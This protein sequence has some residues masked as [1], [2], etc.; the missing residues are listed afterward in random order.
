MYCPVSIVLHY[1][2]FAIYEYRT[3]DDGDATQY[4]ITTLQGLAKR[5]RPDLVSFVT[6]VA[7]RAEKMRQYLVARMLQA[8]RGSNINAI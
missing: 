2:T 5:L 1:T 8:N 6:A 4:L 3:C 7:C